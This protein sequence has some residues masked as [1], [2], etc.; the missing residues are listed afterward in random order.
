MRMV[1]GIEAAREAITRLPGYDDPELSPAAARRTEDLFGEPLTATQAVRRIVDDVRI[2]GD[3]AVREYARRIDGDSLDVL[4]VP[5]EDLAA[6]L[7]RLPAD[8][9][10]ALLVAAGRIRTFH[11]EAMPRDWEDAQA[12]YGVR[13]VPIERVG[14]YV[15]GGT[16]A[17]P[18]S[19]LM[20][21]IPARVAGVDE[22]VLC[23]PAPTDAVLAAAH[24][25]EVD[26]VF[27][28]GGAQAIAAMAYGTESVPRVDKICGPGNIF[29]AIA[30]REVYGQVDIDGLYGPTETVVVADDSADPAIVAADLLAQAEHDE[31]ASP[32]LITSDASLAERVVAEVERQLA[33]LDREAIASAAVAGQG[34]AAV[35]RSVEEAIDLANAYAPEHLCLAVRDAESY[36]PLVRNAGGVFLGEF[37]AEVFGDYVAGP[38]HTMPTAGTARFASSLGVHTF[39]KF[40]PVI[41]LS[42]ATVREIGPAAAAIARIEGLTGH[43]RA[44]EMRLEGEG[45]DKDFFPEGD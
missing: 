26:R 44:A 41:G 36:L 42:S 33:H 35:V 39:L 3:A 11:T 37:S 7:D 30:K 5:R 16:A 31:L 15:P 25:A 32:V 17:Y 4:E 13:V 20:G 34:V 29:V 21:A 45:V 2:K 28:I 27:T 24:I 10:E 18:S 23:T 40:V 19:V 8:I 12:G 9:T 14:I 38:S 22:I 6:A 1:I 43:A